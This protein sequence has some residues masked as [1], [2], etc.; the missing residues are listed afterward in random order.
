MER[1]GQLVICWHC[2]SSIVHR[3]PFTGHSLT[4]A[5]ATRPQIHVDTRVGRWAGRQMRYLNVVCRP[6]KRS[7][8]RTSR[9]T[10]NAQRSTHMPYL[11]RKFVIEPSRHTNNASI[12]PFNSSSLPSIH[13]HCFC[14]ICI[15]IKLYHESHE[16][17]K[18]TVA[19]T[20]LQRTLFPASIHS[21]I[22]MEQTRSSH[23]LRHHAPQS[24]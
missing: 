2:P 18:G 5:H 13:P 22:L 17:T 11:T 15:Y 19:H 16:F 14:H 20:I 10:L 8:R 24:N 3:S 12:L 1:T 7:K 21:S 6:T 23:C 4:R 9:H